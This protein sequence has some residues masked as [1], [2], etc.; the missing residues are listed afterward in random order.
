MT[1]LQ[2]QFTERKRKIEKIRAFGMD[3]YPPTAHRTHRCREV[4]EAFPSLLKKP[5]V[6]IVAGRVKA[7]RG[8]GGSLFLVL[9]DGTA[10][11]QCYAKRDTFGEEPYRRL[12]DN[13][14][15]GDFL[16]ITGTAFTT[17]RGEKSLLARSFRFLAKSLYPQ[18]EKW[19]GL[20]DVEIRYRQRELD[21]MANPAVRKV[22]T[23]R[24]RIVQAIRTFLD[25]E[26]FLEVQTPILQTIAGGA[27]ARPFVTHHNAL[28]RDFFLRVAPELYLKRLIVGGFERVYELG[29]C[30]RNEGMDHAHN[31][32]FYQVE[33]YAAYWDLEAM[34][35]CTERLLSFIVRQTTKD[36]ESGEKGI[37]RF[38]IPFARLDF[39][40][41]IKRFA[42]IDID[43]FPTGEALLREAS[44][45]GIA[46]TETKRSNRGRIL[47]AILKTVVRPRLTAPTFVLRY[48]VDLSPLAKRIAG[49]ERYVHRFQLFAQGAEIANAFGELNDPIDQEERFAD[50]ERQRK[51][52]DDEA[53]QSDPA[54][55]D[56][57]RYGMP[58]TAGI[59]IGIE[60]LVILLSGEPS[61][62]DVILFPT[63]KPKRV[64]KESQ[65]HA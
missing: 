58:P 2:D 18:P 37:A 38:T 21:L 8:H 5:S 12:V 56:A 3:P 27:T 36:R 43:D 14:D 61:I 26:G 46:I 9:D 63:L 19:H 42:A 40:E 52:G 17:R 53:Q 23:Y 48:P 28:D 34:M 41:A 51:A 49:D 31:P 30:F 7:I 39:R 47:D 29:P 57:L 64:R 10:S 35:A 1:R 54:F 44:R 16:E 60:R 13:V 32:E 6:V 33:F 62:K 59:G 55:L 20:K 22:F 45:R 24:A 11:L 25:R 15:L 50:Q 4:L 65:D